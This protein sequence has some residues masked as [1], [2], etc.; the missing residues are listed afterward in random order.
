MKLAK[1]SLFIFMLCLCSVATIGVAGAAPSQGLFSVPVKTIDGVSRTLEPERG[2]VIMVVNTASQCGYTPQYEGLQKLYQ[3]YKSAGLVVLGFPSN[4]FGGQEPG[5]NS[6]I[7]LFCQGTYHV[8]FPLFEKGSVIGSKTQP[9]YVQLLQESADHSAIEWNFEKFLISRNGKVIK[10]FRS[11]V[12]P[13]SDELDRAVA[14]ALR[15]CEGGPCK[16]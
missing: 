15:D 9:F 6:S 13:Q 8:T 2:R 5:S 11:G 7:K 16:K 14:A 12:E 4:D 3:K 10:R 1:N